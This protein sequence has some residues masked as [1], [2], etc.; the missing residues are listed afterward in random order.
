MLKIVK[1]HAVETGFETLRNLLSDDLQAVDTL[2][3][4]CLHSDVA[5]INQLSHY[6]VNSG[7]KR[8]RPMLFTI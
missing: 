6:I 2:I 5:L 7:G 1:N 3:H 4:R 8:L